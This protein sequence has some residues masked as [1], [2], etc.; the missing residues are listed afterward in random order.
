[1]R[2]HKIP[3]FLIFLI[4]CFGVSAQQK[5][6]PAT[7]ISWPA[8]TGTV[9]PTSSCTSLNYGMPYVDVTSG[10]SYTCT[11]LG[12]VPSPIGTVLS[13]NAGQFGYYATTGTTITG[14]TLVAA[15]IAALGTLSNATTGNAATSTNSTEVGGV[16]ISGTPVAGYIPVATGPTTATWQTDTTTNPPFSAL[17]TG[18]NTTM[19]GTCGAGCTITYS[20]AGVINASSLNGITA[21][22]F[23]TLAG[24]NVWTGSNVVSTGGSWTYAGSGT[25]NASSL[26]GV[27]LSGLCQT[28]GAG[29]PSSMTVPAPTTTTLGGLFSFAPVANEFLTGVSTTGQPTAAQPAFTNIS[30]ALGCGQLPGLTGGVSNSGCAVTLTPSAVVAALSGQTVT[31]GALSISSLTIPAATLNDCLVAGV[32]GAIEYQPCSSAGD[33]ASLNVSQTWTALQTFSAAISASNIT[34]TGLTTV[35]NC[36]TVGTGGLFTSAACGGGST[37]QVK[38]GTLTSGVGSGACIN[39]SLSGFT[40]LTSSSAFSISGTSNIAYAIT[41]MVQ[42]GSST[43]VTVYACNATATGY[44]PPSALSVPYAVAAL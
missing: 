25:I 12:W 16:T 24:A 9:S 41:L 21:S 4:M 8:I 28:G 39:T 1:M 35:G 33:Y 20:G 30:G 6:N 37:I 7:Q 44:F 18:T 14:H 27:L 26:A 23:A 15:D 42:F 34:D 38:T 17:A 19:T 13:G 3:L 11:T 43:A 2:M 10:V 40:G 29:C 32:G 31:V 22:S 36:V 5:V